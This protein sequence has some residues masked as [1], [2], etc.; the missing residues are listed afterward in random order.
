MMKNEPSEKFLIRISILKWSKNFHLK[1]SVRFSFFLTGT[2]HKAKFRA[3]W[4]KHI[5]HF[6]TFEN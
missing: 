3:N 4:R 2:Q 5:K 1:S 6:F